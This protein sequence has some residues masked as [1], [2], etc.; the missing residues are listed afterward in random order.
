[1][2]KGESEEILKIAHK[3]LVKS[4]N[5]FGSGETLRLLL[6]FSQC[7][8]IMNELLTKYPS[9]VAIGDFLN[10][11]PTVHVAPKTFQTLVDANPEIWMKTEKNNPEEVRNVCEETPR[12]PKR[13]RNRKRNIASTKRRQLPHKTPDTPIP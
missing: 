3:E 9:I 6:A 2:D 1:M 7:D 10:G 11:K 4:L 5:T 12:K 8:P 13:T